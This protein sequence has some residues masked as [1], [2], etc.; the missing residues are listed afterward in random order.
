VKR[1]QWPGAVA[2]LDGYLDQAGRVDLERMGLGTGGPQ[3]TASAVRPEGGLAAWAP[4]AV[5][6][7]AP[8]AA[9][10]TPV[11]VSAAIR[12]LI[13]ISPPQVTT[14]CSRLGCILTVFITAMRRNARTRRME[15]VGC[16]RSGPRLTGAAATRADNGLVVDIEPGR[17]EEMVITA[18]D[19]LPEDLGPLMHTVAVTVEHDSGPPGLLG[20]TRASL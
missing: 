13:G 20:L 16:Q 7:T 15:R 2:V 18:L 4:A 1:Q 6:A 10:I 9:I 8:R 19:G 12:C 17:F 3:G 14:E 5:G 11:P